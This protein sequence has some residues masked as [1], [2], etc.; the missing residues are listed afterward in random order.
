MNYT[1]VNTK[2][3]AMGTGD[4]NYKRIVAW[5]PS[6]GLRDFIQLMMPGKTRDIPDYLHLWKRI[7]QLDGS[8]RRALLPLVGM[9][10]DLVN[11]VWMF[12][13]KRYYGISGDKT[14]GWLIPVVY[15]LTQEQTRQMGNTQDDKGLL[16]L[17]KQTPYGTV[18]ADFDKPEQR[19]FS[20]LEG[21][22]KKTARLYP[23]SLAPV[24]DFLF[25]IQMKKRFGKR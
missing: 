1:A 18:F 13:L 25:T 24:C 21:Q 14:Y 8:N 2:I 3:S 7:K 23:Q 20:I 11:I 12:R 15:R 9:E 16:A 17:L 5:L 10:I 22:Y 4:E 6:K 19:M